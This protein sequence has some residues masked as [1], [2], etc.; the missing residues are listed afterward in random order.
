VRPDP[1]LNNLH[2]APKFLVSSSPL[3]QISSNLPFSYSSHTHFLLTHTPSLSQEKEYSRPIDTMASV[4]A[5]TV[6]AV[7]GL[8]PKKK[9]VSY[10]NLLLGAALNMFEYVPAP[11]TLP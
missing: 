9:P 8:L 2:S 3:I 10:S 5:A 4:Q 1:N 7:P 6:P 11:S